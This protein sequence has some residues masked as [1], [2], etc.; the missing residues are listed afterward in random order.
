ML[1]GTSFVPVPLAFGNQCFRLFIQV[2]RAGGRDLETGD[3]EIVE[4]ALMH[5]GNPIFVWT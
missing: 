2:P 5:K 4:L 1:S 3:E